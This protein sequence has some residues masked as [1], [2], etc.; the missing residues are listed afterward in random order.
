M[1][2]DKCDL[3]QGEGEEIHRARAME[4]EEQV[5]HALHRL[6][7]C[8][9][10]MPEAAGLHRNL[11]QRLERDGIKIMA[12]YHPAALLRDPTRRP[13]A[14]GDLME[15]R[16]KIRSVCERTEIKEKL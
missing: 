8:R 16:A 14:F 13:D 5:M 7:G 11:R 6:H 3:R 10:G 15:L 1:L 9:Q 12:M 2:N 4:G